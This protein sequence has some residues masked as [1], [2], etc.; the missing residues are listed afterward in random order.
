M[1]LLSIAQCSGGCL[2]GG[3]CEAPDTC[4]CTDTGWDGPRC[5]QGLYTKAFLNWWTSVCVCV[6]ARS[7][8]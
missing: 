7:Y 1:S 3:Y 8:E 6:S 5:A 4:N 2:N